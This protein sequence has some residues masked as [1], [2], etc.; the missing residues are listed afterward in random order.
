MVRILARIWTDS[1]HVRREHRSDSGR[2]R[3]TLLRLFPCASGSREQGVPIRSR[4]FNADVVGLEPIDRKTLAAVRKLQAEEARL[5]KRLLAEKITAE[6]HFLLWSQLR[7][8]T[9]P[10]VHQA[11]LT[12]ERTRAK[13]PGNEPGAQD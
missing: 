11:R 8:R 7:R 10:E 1:A 4:T 3:A 5:H 12:I 13:A 6:E 9:P 2:A